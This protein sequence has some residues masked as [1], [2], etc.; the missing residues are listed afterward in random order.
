M[1]RQQLQVYQTGHKYN[2]FASENCNAD[3]LAIDAL[4]ANVSAANMQVVNIPIA[5]ILATDMPAIDILEADVPI[6]GKL[7]MLVEKN[8]LLSGF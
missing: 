6:A 4:A 1:W 7:E 2:F 8:W 5:D 3:E